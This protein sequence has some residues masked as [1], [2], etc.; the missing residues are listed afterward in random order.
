MFARTSFSL[1]CANSF[2]FRL[3]DVTFK[4]PCHS[5]LRNLLYYCI[6]VSYCHRSVVVAGTVRR[7][8]TLSKRIL[9]VSI[10]LVYLFFFVRP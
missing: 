7:S 5:V 1:H 4:R 9:A 6:R 3:L 10:V 8:V 2:V